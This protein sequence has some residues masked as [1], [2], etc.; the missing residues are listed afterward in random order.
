MS[1]KA[2]WW[3]WSCVLHENVTLTLKVLER[4]KIMKNIQFVMNLCCI[5]SSSLILNII[6]KLRLANS[7]ITCCIDKVLPTYIVEICTFQ[8]G[9]IWNLKNRKS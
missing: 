9:R 2:L 7:L 6:N 3:Y 1:I 8:N 4:K 5:I